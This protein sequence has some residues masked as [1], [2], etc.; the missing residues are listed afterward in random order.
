[1][2]A[3]EKDALA[4]RQRQLLSEVGARI[5]NIVEV[6]EMDTARADQD[7]VGVNVIVKPIITRVLG[8]G[9]NYIG[10]LEYSFINYV[11]DGIVSEFVIMQ[12]KKYQAT[13]EQVSYGDSEAGKGAGS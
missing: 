1:M 12:F 3:I 8:N 7:F 6:V 5:F 9:N 2:T 11:G 13:V 4:L 10:S